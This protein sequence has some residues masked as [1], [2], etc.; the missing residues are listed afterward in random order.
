[1]RENS[2]VVVNGVADESEG[3]AKVDESGERGWL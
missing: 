1:M 3:R 2:D